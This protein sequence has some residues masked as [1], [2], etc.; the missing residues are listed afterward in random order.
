MDSIVQ[1]KREENCSEELLD[2]AM[3]L[4]VDAI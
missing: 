4:L 2:A 1:P 3:A